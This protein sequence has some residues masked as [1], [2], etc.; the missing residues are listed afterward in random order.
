MSNFSFKLFIYVLIRE[1]A[2]SWRFSDKIILSGKLTKFSPSS[3]SVV[4]SYIS[5]SK[6]NDR[7]V[8]AAKLTQFVILIKTSFICEALIYY[9][10]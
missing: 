9:W 4:I 5:G 8:F 7:L 1:N 2:Q 3:S 10:I 6:Q